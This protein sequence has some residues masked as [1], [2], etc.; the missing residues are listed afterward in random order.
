VVIA[1][2][3][4]KEFV[5][6]PSTEKPLELATWYQI[7]AWAGILVLCGYATG[8]LFREMHESYRGILLMLRYFLM[9][10]EASQQQ[11]RRIASYSA[12]IAQ[13]RGMN[14]DE[15]EIVRAAALLRDLSALEISPE[16]LKK[17]ARLTASVQ[18][19]KGT[20][21]ADEDLIRLRKVLPLVIAEMSK[22]EE[23][24]SDPIKVIELAEE[25][26]ALVSGK[27]GKTVH[28]EVA[29]SL[30]ARAAGG[31]FDEETVSAFEAAF[32]RGLL[33]RTEVNA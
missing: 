16:V 21:F 31:R 12:A 33:A 18:S 22:S 13:E 10:D 8:G 29:R 6:A 7:A 4:L 11:V 20:A 26:E 5:I 32:N 14:R 28:P 15:V 25:F 3:F 2:V 19:E 27:H 1:G 17:T 23:E 24:K 9:R 30:I